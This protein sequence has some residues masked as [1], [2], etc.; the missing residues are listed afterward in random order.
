MCHKL[1]NYGKCRIQDASRNCLNYFSYHVSQCC[2]E[3]RVPDSMFNRPPLYSGEPIETLTDSR[4]QQRI[5]RT[6]E[7]II[8]GPLPPISQLYDKHII[9][10]VKDT[11]HPSHAL[12]MAIDGEQRLFP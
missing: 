2:L 5:V 8:G 12:W 1:L 4:G 3:I 7:R 10:R 11:F 6:A 9:R